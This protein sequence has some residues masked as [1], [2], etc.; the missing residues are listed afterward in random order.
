MIPLQLIA[1]LLSGILLALA[2]PPAAQTSLVWVA[3]VPLL[4]IVRRASPRFA[5]LCGW[6]GGSAFWL[7]TL[8]WMWR[9][10]ENNGPWFLVYPAWFA[11]SLYLAL[12]MGLFACASAWL[13][14]RLPRI[15][16][17]FLEPILWSGSEY[18]RAT[19][20]TGFSW[21]SLGVA[22][23]P[24]P[25]LIQSAA[26]GGAYLVSA[27]AVLGNEAVAT[28]L[29]NGFRPF[30]LSLQQQPRPK[31]DLRQRLAAMAESLLPL[32]VILLFSWWGAARIAAF[33]KSEIET[34]RVIGVQTDTPCV[35]TPKTEAEINRRARETHQQ[36]QLFGALD[37]ALVVW[38]ESALLGAVPTDED[39][40][41]M[42]FARDCARAANAP[43]L[44]G[45]TYHIPEPEQYYNAA[46][47]FIPGQ[48][49]I[50]AYGKRHL[51]PFGEYIPF[52]KTFTFLQDW[53]PG[54]VSCTP[55]KSVKT[56]DVPLKDG[57][58]LVIG[59][60]I[61]FEDT[62]APVARDAVRS[63][64]RLLVNLTNDAW[65]A[66]SSEGIQHANQAILRC[67]ETG[68]P[69]VRSTNGGVTCAINPVGLI[70][71]PA[72]AGSSG[73]IV[74]PVPLLKTPFGTPLYLRTGDWLFAIPAAAFLLITLAFARITRKTK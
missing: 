22:L 7:L 51:V 71:T 3:L 24:S 37:A 67:V 13:R 65:Y 56:L 50:P 64:A 19:V 14:S 70:Q 8:G 2:F 17:L 5:F 45:G 49:G 33:E 18:L 60:L 44:T 42:A 25:M 10:T 57:G 1:S 28:L 20:F 68:V 23:V 54:G 27:L 41:W 58:K 6:L 9:L 15:P 69:M 47:L 35:F 38:P 73:F 48:T 29:E 72:P 53:V 11:L 63:G 16:A 21:N 74:T 39:R 66:P 61:C 55:G 31:P 52:D 59:P 12:Y 34:V 62:V 40:G 32:M 46:M 36:S 4:L 43:L 26:L 30:L